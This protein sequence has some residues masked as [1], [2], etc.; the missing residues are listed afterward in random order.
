M[1]Q[2]VSHH[3]NLYIEFLNCM[4]MLFFFFNL[5]S[6]SSGI[7]GPTFL[8]VQAVSGIGLS[9]GTWLFTSR[10]I[11]YISGSFLIGSVLYNRIDHSITM[12]TVAVILAASMF[13]I[14]WCS[15]YAAMVT[16]YFVLGNTAG[17]IDTGKLS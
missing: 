13:A 17:V 1:Q 15:V 12:A 5:Q 8:D 4:C 6:S 11:G 7:L 16:V 2:K 14:P 10:S 9:K 3:Y